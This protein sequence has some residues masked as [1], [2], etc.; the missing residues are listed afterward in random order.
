MRFF[1]FLYLESNQQ[2]IAKSIGINK[3]HKKRCA[4][5]QLRDDRFESRESLSILNIKKTSAS[6]FFRFIKKQKREKTPERMWF[7]GCEIVR[8]NER[9]FS[10]FVCS[11][12]DTRREGVS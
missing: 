11:F 5:E 12:R 2:N 4:D 3:G 9:K 6:R 8:A 10:S 1:S 7:D